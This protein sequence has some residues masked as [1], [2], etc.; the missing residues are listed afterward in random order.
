MRLC[1]V[2]LTRISRAGLGIKLNASES[3]DFARREVDR[4]D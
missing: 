2:G 4:S 1:S 3:A